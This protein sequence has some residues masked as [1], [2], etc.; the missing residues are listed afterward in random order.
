MVVDR[1]WRKVARPDR[2]EHSKHDGDLVSPPRVAVCVLTRMRENGLTRTLAGIAAQRVSPCDASAVRVLVVDNDP[3]G[4]A[5]TVCDRLLTDYRWSLDYAVESS[6]G[7]PRARNRALELVTEV[8]DLLVFV[9]D[10]EV[11][12]ERWLSELLRVWREYSAD[13][14]LGP[15]GSYFPEAVPGWIERGAFFERQERS[16]GCEC[17]EGATGNVLMTTRMLRESGLRFDER[18]RLSGG[19]DGFFFQR[20]RQAGYRMVWADEAVVRE[21]IPRSRATLKWLTMRHF[22][23]GALVGESLPIRGRLGAAARGVARLGIGAIC[24]VAFLPFG[25]H[26][27]V[28]AIRWASYGLGLLYGVTGGLYPEYREPRSV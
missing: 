1:R 27:S 26:R 19:S 13:V 21:W 14:V 5:K 17:A 11:P 8:D 24:A 10:D 4:S 3:S 2:G 7:I 16:T 25:R 15:V 9:D 23:N 20:V 28:K 18:Y 12:C 22:R 6:V